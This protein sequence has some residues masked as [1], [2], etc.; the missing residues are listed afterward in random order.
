MPLFWLVGAGG[1][2][3]LAYSIYESQGLI[4]VMAVA[5]LTGAAALVGVVST[6]IR[7]LPMVR[8]STFI[9]GIKAVKGKICPLVVIK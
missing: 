5:V 6:L 9:Q 7:V 1:A 3:G 4:L 2:A 8:D